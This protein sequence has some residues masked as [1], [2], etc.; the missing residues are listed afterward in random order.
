MP[1][2]IFSVFLFLLFLFLPF[3]SLAYLPGFFKVPSS[4]PIVTLFLQA[5]RKT[6]R[7]VE[8]EDPNKKTFVVFHWR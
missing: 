4:V 7:N 1:P 6:A 5:P 3:S 2:L 8:C